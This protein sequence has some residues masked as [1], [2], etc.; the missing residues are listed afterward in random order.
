V[1]DYITIY[2]N[3]RKIIYILRKEKY[4][5]MLNMTD[6]A[7]E[8]LQELL[9]CPPGLE[10]K[11][12]LVGYHAVNPFIAET[13]SARGYMMSAHHSQRLALING[14]E[15]IVQTGLE[16]QLGENTFSS[17]ANS[18]YEVIKVI[19]RYSGIS[20]AYASATVDKIA[21]VENLDTGEIDYLEVPQKWTTNSRFG[22]EYKW[23]K[24]VLDNITTGSII[25]KGTILA[26]SPGITE[27]GGYKHGINANIA[28]ITLPETD[29]DGVVIS[30]SFAKKLMF[31]VY[32]TKVIEFG[33]NTFP[34]NIYGDN[35]NYKPFPD[36]GEHIADHS[37]VMA[38][39]YYNPDISPAVASINDVKDFDPIFDKCYYTRGPGSTI[40]GINGG[41][42]ESGVVVD[43]KAYHN[44]KR[45]KEVYAGTTGVIDKYVNGLRH[46]Y[47]N[48]LDTYTALKTEHY[49]KYKNYDLKL[50]DKFHAL[51][52]DALS[53]ANPKN[54]RME[55]KTRNDDIDLYRIEITIKYAI[56][57]TRGNKLSDGYGSV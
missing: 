39:R 32:E 45:N 8:Y 26:D 25:P 2:Y 50:S 44:P 5:S 6:K 15:K 20:A 18:D 47:Q 33:E 4:G 3:N 31:N 29:K 28:L 52:V 46:Y 37:V 56:T 9:T 41:K 43:I 36:I 53:I 16:K 12:E 19:T 35:T 30:E 54:L 11:E 14:E 34:L 24:K 17:K 10:P 55:Y 27:N 51:I 57:P 49:R 48:I 42:I 22:F 7:K 40:D 1:Y 38:L 23:N 13:S 21:I